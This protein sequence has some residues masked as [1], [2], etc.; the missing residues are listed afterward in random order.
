MVATDM[1]LTNPNVNSGTAVVLQGAKFSWTWKNL[2]KNEAV[3]GKYDIQESRFGGFL[4]PKMSLSGFINVDEVPT[5]SLTQSLLMDFLQEKSATTTL[6]ILTGT[7]GTYFKGRPTAGYSVGGTYV[8][9]LKIQ[10]ETANINFATH[11]GDQS[12]E[13]HGWPYTINFHETI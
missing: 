7:S 4:S 12:T 1:T 2:T 5:N 6:V 11:G 8:N 9:S 13:G 3:E 10:L